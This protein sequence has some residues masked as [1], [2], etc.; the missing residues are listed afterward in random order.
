[1][2]VQQKNIRDNTMLRTAF[3]NPQFQY[4]CI[5]VL[6]SDQVLKMFFT[7]MTS[8]TR[9]SIE[10]FAFTLPFYSSTKDGVE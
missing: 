1:M 10:H 6:A 7:P 8:P 4:S 5:L 9:F 3:L 2:I